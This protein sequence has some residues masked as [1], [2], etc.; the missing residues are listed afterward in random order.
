MN[1]V[2]A[3]TSRRPGRRTLFIE[4]KP[5]THEAE[6]QR[7]WIGLLFAMTM[8]GGITAH[9]GIGPSGTR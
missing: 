8:L 4:I 6:G 5:P 1:L 9:Q 3:G 2:P 7:H